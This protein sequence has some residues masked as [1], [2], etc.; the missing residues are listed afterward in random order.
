MHDIIISQ[1]SS[2]N[3]L[4]N[5]AFKVTGESYGDV[6][7]AEEGS[8]PP[9]SPLFMA[10]PSSILFSLLI[11]LIPMDFYHYM[12]LK[13]L[14]RKNNTYFPPRNFSSKNNISTVTS[15]CVGR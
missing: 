12:V 8:T 3:V 4:Q 5:P 2:F 11:F 10:R 15:Q 9:D 7:G 14:K 1:S 6:I 13:R